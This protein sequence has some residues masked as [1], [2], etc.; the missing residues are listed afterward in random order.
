MRLGENGDRQIYID[1]RASR[2]II[3][4]TSGGKF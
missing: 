2:I 4:P 1:E 3:E